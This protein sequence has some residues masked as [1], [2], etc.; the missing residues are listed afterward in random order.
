MVSICLLIPLLN[1]SAYKL[2]VLLKRED[3]NH[4]SVTELDSLDQSRA[5]DQNV[6]GFNFA[7]GVFP[8]FFGSFQGNIEDFLDIRFILQSGRANR[9]DESRRL[10]MHRCNPDDVKLFNTP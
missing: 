1:Y 7:I 9:V 10:G 4:F 2:Q 6:T 8:K 3:T 5:F